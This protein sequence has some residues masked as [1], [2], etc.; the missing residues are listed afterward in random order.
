MHKPDVYGLLELIMSTQLVTIILCLL[1][2]L[3][4]VPPVFSFQ[5]D[6]TESSYAIEL[7]Q[8]NTNILKT[9][10]HLLRNAEPIDHALKLIYFLY[11]RSSLTGDYQQFKEVETE[12]EHTLELYGPHPQLYLARA[13][14]HFKLHRLSQTKTDLEQIPFLAHSEVVRVLEADIALQEGRYQQA[15]QGYEQALTKNDSWDNL[16]RLA[17]FKSNIGEPDHADTLYHKAQDQLTAKQMRPYAWL[18]LQRGLLDFDQERYD[19]ALAHYHQ[20]EKAYSGHWLIEEHQAEVL[21]V[22]GRTDDAVTLYHHI[23]QKTQKPEFLSALARI[24]ERTHSTQALS[25]WQ[26]AEARYN[27]QFALYPEATIGHLITDLLFHQ[28][29]DDSLLDLATRNYQL[30][31]NS[32]S[33]LVLAKVHMKLGNL[34][35]ASQ[36]LKDISETLWKPPD[37]FRLAKQVAMSKA[38]DPD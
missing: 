37:F 16:A 20:A 36:L 13:H 26:Q 6:E 15:L 4:V 19:D 11:Q 34:D 25:L 33:K 14:L 22:L 18:E 29:P 2:S 7:Q 17:F 31:P 9:R 8:L 24:L 12:I 1:L 30:R 27:K 21:A 35:L 32:D 23:I 10:E 38:T 3:I 28:V 5:L